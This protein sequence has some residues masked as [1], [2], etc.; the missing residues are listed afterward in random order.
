[1]ETLGRAT[2]MKKKHTFK[3]YYVVW[4]HRHKIEVMTDAKAFKS[5]YVVWKRIYSSTKSGSTKR[6]K[7]YYVVWKL[8]IGMGY[9]PKKIIV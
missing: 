6:F 5:Y 3:S 1:M 8:I 4:K 2:Q 9:L 7:S